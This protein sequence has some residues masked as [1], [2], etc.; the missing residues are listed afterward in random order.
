MNAPLDSQE[1]DSHKD[2]STDDSANSY[3]FV[4]VSNRL[5]VDRVVD[6]EGNES[7]KGSPGGLVTALEPIMRSNDGAWVGWGGQADLDIEPFDNDGIHIVSV[8]L[9]ADDI[10]KYYEGFS[11][12]T[13]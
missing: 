11:N 2:P 9:S 3:E 10:E 4:V 6:A 5:P 12:D 8:P 7:W 1:V 13:L